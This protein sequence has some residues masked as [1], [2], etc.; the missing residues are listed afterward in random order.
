MQDFCHDV[1]RDEVLMS[2]EMIHTKLIPG[3][4]QKSSNS[5]RKVE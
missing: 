2:H 1:T 4:I 5:T 3:I